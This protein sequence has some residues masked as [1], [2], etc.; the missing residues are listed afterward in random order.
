MRITDN[1]MTK[2]YLKNLARNQQN[3][4]KYH[5]QL[6]S[7]KEVSKPSDN[8]L[9]VSQIIGLKENV[10]SNQQYQP[11][12][13]DAIDWSNMQDASLG[14]ATD[15]LMRISTLV[16]S[17]ATDTMNASDRLIVKAEIETEIQTFV[18]ALNTNYGGR[19]IF[20]GTETLKTPFEMIQDADGALT[21]IT[22]NG[23]SQNIS[24]E[25][26]PGV[27]VDLLTN[28][29]G[30]LNDNAQNLGALFKEVVSAL[31]NDDTKAVAA[32]VGKVTTAIDHVV[33]SRTEIGAV[34]NRLGSAL[35]RN[36][37]Q[38]LNLREMLS[39]KED[40]DF[41]KK[42]MQFSNEQVA[43]QASLQMGTKILNTTILDYL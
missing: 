33:S 28:G 20:G 30:I 35:S 22:Y 14:K 32:T 8:P 7:M 38:D 13:K 4:Q 3:V 42:Y 26:S 43:Y 18:D 2:S 34:S 27:T 41:A 24:R 1:M 40:I 9:L 17:A 16:Q 15:S 29:A 12:I 5:H 21:G 11:T 39:S 10:S 19:Y 6:S 23:T 37:S 25:I 31:R 36:E